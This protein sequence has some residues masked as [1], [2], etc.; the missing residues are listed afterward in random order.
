V[1]RRQNPQ[2]ASQ[3]K[4]QG[5]VRRDAALTFIGI[6]ILDHAVFTLLLVF[7]QREATASVVIMAAVYMQTGMG[8][9]FW[10]YFCSR[11]CRDGASEDLMST[12][13]LFT[14]ALDITQILTSGLIETIKDI[15]GV[16]FW[17]TL[18]VYVVS[19]IDL[20]WA[21]VSEVVLY[22]RRNATMSSVELRERQFSR[23]DRVAE[24]RAEGLGL[25]ESEA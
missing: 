5:E 25:M 12:K 17:L 13:K 19:A 21:W 24:K 18:L 3:A 11:Y 23:V 8:W 14:S 9:A 15:Q 16:P 22:N 1:T 2:S 4:L 6:D 7:V 10:L 20:I